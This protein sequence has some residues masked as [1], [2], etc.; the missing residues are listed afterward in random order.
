MPRPV[1]VRFSSVVVLFIGSL[2]LG[3]WVSNGSI[4]AEDPPVAK[5]AGST[6]DLEPKND[7]T[8]RSPVEWLLDPVK[9][10]ES[11]AKTEAEMKKY[12]EKIPGTDVAFDML[13]I[14]GGV[15]QMGSPESEANRS[16]CEGPQRKATVGPLWM[17]KCEVTWDEYELWGIGLDMQFRKITN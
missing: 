1:C 4:F 2:V 14:P 3:R 8:L 10:P 9:I 16:E 6:G 5:V 7:P 17:G 11:E 15:F 12:N 13:P